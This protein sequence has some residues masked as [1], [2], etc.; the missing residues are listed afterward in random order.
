MKRFL[1]HAD[2]YNPAVDQLTKREKKAVR[3]T[4]TRIIENSKSPGL[5]REKY[6]PGVYTYRV[7]RDLRVVGYEFG[8]DVTLLYVAH[9]DKANDW[10]R[11]HRVAPVEGGVRL[12]L[13]D[14]Q[15]EPAHT[16]ETS[17]LSNTSP[18]LS[19]LLESDALIA[20]VWQATDTARAS[21]AADILLGR[22][23]SKNELL[24]AKL[25]Q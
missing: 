21:H 13:T 15:A 1:N 3:K 20:E 18:S 6:R 7:N 12:V 19:D 25:P 2:T 23:V 24:L 4:E 14:M 5:H 17:D 11:R 8:S 10:A 9:H 16:A 22:I